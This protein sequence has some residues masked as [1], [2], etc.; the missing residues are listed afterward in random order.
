MMLGELTP[1]FIALILGIVFGAQFSGQL[2]RRG[3]YFIIGLAIV[4]AFLFGA[5][6]FT[7]SIFGGYIA[8]D[9]SFST[10]FLGATI[11]ILIGRYAGGK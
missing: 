9:L 8:P 6:I 4:A 11:G 10:P 7:S 5:P 1:C 3:I 2:S